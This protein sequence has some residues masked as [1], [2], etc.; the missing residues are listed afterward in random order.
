MADFRNDEYNRA[1]KW[2]VCGSFC[3][4]DEWCGKA[5]F[6]QIPVSHEPFVV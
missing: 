3:Y 1:D 2:S 6:E 4:L 5:Y